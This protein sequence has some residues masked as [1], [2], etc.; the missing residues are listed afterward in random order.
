V[1]RWRGRIPWL[2][3]LSRAAVLLAVAV[4]VSATLAPSPE[5]PP[6][7]SEASPSALAGSVVVL[8]SV[9]EDGS[10]Y[11]VRYVIDADRTLGV[12]AAP[13]GSSFDVV[14]VERER[15]LARVRSLPSSRAPSFDAFISYVGSIH[16]T[17]TTRVDGTDTTALWAAAV[18]G[19][20]VGAPR[21]VVP[22][23]GFAQLS[24]S[25]H[26]VIV[27]DGRVS[28]AAA[29]GTDQSATV[30][31]SAP[32]AGGPVSTRSERTW[33]GGWRQIDRPWLASTDPGPLVLLNQ[34]TGE[35][36]TVPGS[37]VTATGCV[38]DRC[39]VR[40]ISGGDSVRLE[41]MAPDGSDRTAIAGPATFF[42]AV[43]PLTLGRYE[44]L[45]QTGADLAPGQMRLL[46]HDVATGTTREVETGPRAQVSVRDGWAWWL[47]GGSNTAVWH[48]LH[49]AAL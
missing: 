20:R 9:L 47:A 38:P 19:T 33:P 4:L 24:G 21:I 10:S 14:V 35:R 44:L 39:R 26:D 12:A 45:S 2:S 36:V 16:W 18:S 46:L 48:A 3:G 34:D 42:A 13:D 7:A 23:M 49:L 25:A 22:D 17:E 37:D 28:W 1:R 40:V 8:P 30:V 41:L 15:I 32:V 31:R 5:G 43:D 29:S 6:A 11:T 27:A